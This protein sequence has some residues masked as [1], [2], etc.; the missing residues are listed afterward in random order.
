[1]RNLDKIFNPKSV[2]IIGASSKEK[3]VGFGLVENILTGKDMRQVFLVNLNQGEILGNK[4]YA[5]IADIQEEVDLAVVAVPAQFVLQVVGEC[6]DKKV[7]GIIVISSG[8]A[9][10]GKEGQARQEEILEKV[11][12]ADIPMLGPNCLGIIR[13]KSKLNASFAPITPSQG[14]VAFISQSGALLDA[15][16]DGT[17]GLVSSAISYGNETDVDLIDIME[18]FGQDE[19]TKVIAIY[20]EAIK[21]GRRFMDAAHKITKIKPI[22]VIKSGKFSAG[23]EAV[24]SHTGSLAGDYETYKAVFKQVGIIEADSTEELID[25]SRL[26]SWQPLCTNSFAIVTNGGGCGVMAVDY[27]KMQGV[28]LAKLSKETIDKISGSTEMNKFWSKSNPVDVIGDASPAR[29]RV[30]I[31]AVLSQKNVGGLMVIQTPQ[32]MTDPLENAKIIIEMKK[33]FPE[34]P[35]ICF[36]LGGKMSAEAIKILEENHIP[37]YSEIKRGVIAIKALI[38]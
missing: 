19:E 37:N 8:F 38:K 3:S 6:C 30:A 34:K 7:G 10:A 9:E 11:Q 24:K 31:E 29:Y 36:F 14:D 25:I 12:K 28:N 17:E 18:W 26:L 21:D 23:K 35:I 15:I 22:V 32:I 27:C 5:K 20:L 13:T 4:T 2:A 16:I 1:M 33:L